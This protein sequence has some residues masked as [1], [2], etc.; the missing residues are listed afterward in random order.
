MTMPSVS[1]DFRGLHGIKVFAVEIAKSV[2]ELQKFQSRQFEFDFVEQSGANG[3]NVQGHF[4]DQGLVP[5]VLG[6]V[7]LKKARNS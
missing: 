4:L 2:T 6:Q 3:R 5:F 7:I 1:L